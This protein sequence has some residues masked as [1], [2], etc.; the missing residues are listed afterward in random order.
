MDRDICLKN[1]AECR[2]KAKT[3]PARADQWTD[4][5]N[6]WLQRASEAGGGKA[7]SYEIHDGRMIPKSTK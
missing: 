7:I 4:E 6:I 3:D 5:A 1:A 2:E